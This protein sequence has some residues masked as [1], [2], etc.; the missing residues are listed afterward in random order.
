MNERYAQTL[1]RGGKLLLV[2]ESGKRQMK[3]T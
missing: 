3:L 2:N 1:E